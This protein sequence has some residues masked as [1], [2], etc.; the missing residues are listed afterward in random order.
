MKRREFTTKIKAEIVKRA[1][2]NNEI[3]CEA[4]LSRSSGQSEEYQWALE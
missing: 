1:M 3:W 4:N 2:V